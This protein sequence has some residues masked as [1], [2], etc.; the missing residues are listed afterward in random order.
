MICLTIIL[1]CA[2][3]E[4]RKERIA[5]KW[6]PGKLIASFVTLVLTALMILPVSLIQNGEAV[7]SNIAAQQERLAQLEQIYSDENYKPK[8]ESECVGTDVTEKVNSGTRLN[9][10][11]VLGTHN[12]YELESQKIYQVLQD[13]VNNITFGLSNLNQTRLNQ[14]TL[15]EQFDLGI[16]SVE[17]DI[18]V[19]QDKDGTHF[20]CCHSPMIDNNST[21][22]DF[23]LALKEIK[24]WSDAHPDH[25]PIS[26]LIEVKKFFLPVNGFR[27]FTVN[28]A[29]AFGS[30]VQEIFGSTLLTPADVMGEYETFEQMRK[31]NAWPTLKETQGKVMLLLHPTNITDKYISQDETLKTQTMFP[32]LRFSDTDKPYASFILINMPEDVAENSEKL[33]KEGNFIVR[34]RTDDFGTFSEQWDE[35]AM[36]CGSQILSTDYPKK[37]DMSKV[38]RV[39]TFEGG[40]TVSFKK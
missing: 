13:C 21:C 5:M 1:V 17:L 34:T 31:N 26:V 30:L 37:T 22:Y 40:A 36:S 11:R 23:S 28:D 14:D 3:I 16:R 39:V 24:M 25:L 38:Q 9:E 29:N 2:K 33:F 4:K 35:L 12:S 10:V 15:T 20:V 7:K 32:M 19:M 27:T 18:E 8:S 6:F